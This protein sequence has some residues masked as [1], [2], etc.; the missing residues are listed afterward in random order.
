MFSRFDFIKDV[1]IAV[2]VFAVAFGAV[3]AF[4]VHCAALS[5]AY[6]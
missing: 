6:R 1:A 4:A 3:A 2:V 5:G